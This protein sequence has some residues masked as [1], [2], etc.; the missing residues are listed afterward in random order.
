M[1]S[2]TRTVTIEGRPT[3]RTK[4]MKVKYVRPKK[5]NLYHSENFVHTG[6]ASSMSNNLLNHFMSV[7]EYD[8]NLQ[9]VKFRAIKSGTQTDREAGS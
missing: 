5:P 1:T 2:F 6:N 4:T 9:Y 3:K 7:D 8:S